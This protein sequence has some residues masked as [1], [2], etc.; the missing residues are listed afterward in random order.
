MMKQCLSTYG[1]GNMEYLMYEDTPNPVFVD[2]QTQPFNKL[3]V[4]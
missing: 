2:Q 3:T 4:C 1:L